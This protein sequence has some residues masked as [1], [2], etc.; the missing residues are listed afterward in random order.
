M[1]LQVERLSARKCKN[2]ALQIAFKGLL[3]KGNRREFKTWYTDINDVAIL[4]ACIYQFSY[5]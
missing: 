4:K 5:I 3:S 1:V 2:K